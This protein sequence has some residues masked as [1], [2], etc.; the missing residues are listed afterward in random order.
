M[1]RQLWI[2]GILDGSSRVF[3][4]LLFDLDNGRRGGQEERAGGG[5][6]LRG[7]RG[8]R[9]TLVTGESK[10]ALAAINQ[11]CFVFGALARPRSRSVGGGWMGGW[12]G[13]GPRCSASARDPYRSMRGFTIPRPSTS[14]TNPSRRGERRGRPASI[15]NRGRLDE[16]R[17]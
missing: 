2:K 7:W 9:G 4:S 17:S 5:G 1:R 13:G 8:C 11:L 10:R 6:G 15:A 3:S 16:R 14:I 12:G